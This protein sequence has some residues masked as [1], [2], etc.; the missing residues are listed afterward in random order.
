MVAVPAATGVLVIDMAAIGLAGRHVRLRVTGNPM[1]YYFA[2]RS[3][4]TPPAYTT[5]DSTQRAT[6]GADGRQTASPA[7]QATQIPAGGEARRFVSGKFPMLLANGV[8][9]AAVLE[10]EDA[11]I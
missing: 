2:P 3:E 11:T 9:G 6:F 8:G 10:I 5:P 1:A 4:A 7:T